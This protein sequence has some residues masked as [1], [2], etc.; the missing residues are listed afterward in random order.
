[1]GPKLPIELDTGEVVRIVEGLEDAAP[2]PSRC[3]DLAAGTVVE[4]HAQPVL[5]DDLD[6]GDPVQIRGRP[7][8]RRLPT[9]PRRRL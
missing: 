4:G 3:V 9:S 2:R 5:A 1:L 8:I 6:L 7:R